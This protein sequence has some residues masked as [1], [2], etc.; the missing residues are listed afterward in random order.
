MSQIPTTAAPE[1][2]PRIYA[3]PEKVT[4]ARHRLVA[5]INELNQ[6]Y[7]GYPVDDPAAVPQSSEFWRG[8]KGISRVCFRDDD[9]KSREWLQEKFKEAGCERVWMDSWGNV[10]AEMGPED[11]TPILVR[12]HTDSVDQGGPLDGILGVM[13]GV[14]LAEYMGPEHI[15]HGYKLVFGSNAAEEMLYGGHYIGSE[16]LAGTMPKEWFD[17]AKSPEGTTLAAD[18]E[19]MGLSHNFDD[20]YPGIDKTALS[21]EVH[22]EQ[23][24][25]L[26]KVNL[27]LGLPERISGVRYY[28]MY[29][30]ANEDIGGNLYS[31]LRPVME[32]GNVFEAITPDDTPMPQPSGSASGVS[33]TH[34][35]VL[36]NNAFQVPGKFSFDLAIHGAGANDSLESELTAL[37]K[38]I[39]AGERTKIDIAGAGVTEDQFSCRITI[40]GYS[41]HE[42]APPMN[43]RRDAF[44]SFCKFRRFF[45]QLTGAPAIE[46]AEISITPTPDT[47]M[48]IG[49]FEFTGNKLYYTVVAKETEVG[50]LNDLGASIEAV[51]AKMPSQFPVQTDSEFGGLSDPV[52]CDQNAIAL[53]EAIAAQEGF[54]IQRMVSMP[55]HDV[56]QFPVPL[57]IFVRNQHGSHNPN[58]TMRA[59]DLD[60][61]LKLVDELLA[62]ISHHA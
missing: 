57:L 58:E 7:A 8:P 62:S 53:A 14:V 30:T 50:V 36:T 12:S 20:V 13:I 54:G 18:M 37:S 35:E 32:M 23:D 39:M 21:I 11:A 6:K 9:M 26:E 3:T 40:E 15:P 10:Y 34:L 38:W 59:E 44:R 42:G 24:D 29:V 61:L 49:L 22:I 2:T 25:Q 51:H 43:E 56:T 55:G 5:I 19:K 16:A 41:E 4:E 48:T 46:P 60:P 17:S 52:K 33:I 27:P 31:L 45:D 47:R 1:S 28:H